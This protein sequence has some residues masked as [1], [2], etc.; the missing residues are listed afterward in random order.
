MSEES[1]GIEIRRQPAE[2]AP[3][4]SGGVTIG[5]QMQRVELH[6]GREQGQVYFLIDCSTSMAGYK[7]EEAKE[8]IIDFVR[9]A[10]RKEYLLGLIEFSSS[11]T[12]LC[13]PGQNITYLR[14]CLKTI[15]ASGGTNMVAAIELAHEALKDIRVDRAIVIATD[16]Q[17]NKVGA[18][19]KAG[20][21]A[22]DDGIDIIAIGTDDADQEF[23]KKIAS[24]ADLGKKVSQENFSQEIASAA[25][26]LPSPRTITK[27]GR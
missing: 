27:P 17:P 23:L 25:Q 20:Q 3:I 24:R 4:I 11:A 14:E 12:I 2:N 15:R 26:L 10:I 8:G 6:L 22:K 21:A 19:L 9:D 7:L 16:G 18:A 1:R 13:K 5:T